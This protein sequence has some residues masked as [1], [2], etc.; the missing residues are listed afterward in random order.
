[1]SKGDNIPNPISE[2]YDNLSSIRNK[3]QEELD[4]V[5]NITKEFDMQKWKKEIIERLE[6]LG[7]TE[8]PKAADGWN[9][10]K[11]WVDECA[12]F[13]KEQWDS[14]CKN[15]GIPTESKF[16]TSTNYSSIEE[17]IGKIEDLRNAARARNN[18]I[19]QLESK[20]E[21]LKFHLRQEVLDGNK[22][23]SVLIRE[24]YNKAIEDAAKMASGEWINLNDRRQICL[25]KSIIESIKTLKKK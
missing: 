24:W 12:N 4:K 18:Q 15:H 10:S 7:N 3:F 5:K 14:I 6:K 20:V 16:T 19:K 2:I 17:A 8:S 21:S 23:S 1:M 25:Q 11:A 22:Y 9:V 13:T